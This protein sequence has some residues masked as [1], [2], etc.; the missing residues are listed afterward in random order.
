MAHWPNAHCKHYIVNEWLRATILCPTKGSFNLS[1]GLFL[2]VAN[3]LH[4]YYDCFCCCSLYYMR[5]ILSIRDEETIVCIFRQ[6]SIEILVSNQPW[7]LL[8]RLLASHAR[9]RST[10][11]V[12]MWFIPSEF[13]S[14]SLHTHWVPMSQW[15]KP[16]NASTNS[17][18]F[19]WLLETGIFNR[20]YES[21]GIGFKTSD[22]L[23]WI[24]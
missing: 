6:S 20:I 10:N 4:S 22:K 3:L 1:Y 9:S 13:Q 12:T 8:E 24:I 19:I 15:V 18:Q 7:P 17:I 23:R 2:L 14:F 11:V 16:P 21:N 5:N